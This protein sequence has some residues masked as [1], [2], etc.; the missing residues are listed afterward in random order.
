MKIEHIIEA[1]SKSV[2]KKVFDEWH[3]EGDIL[4]VDDDW[5]SIEIDGERY[6]IMVTQKAVENEETIEAE[7]EPAEIQAE[8]P[9]EVLEPEPK[10]RKKIDHLKILSLHNAG[11]SNKQI[12][13][14]MNLTPNQI[15]QSLS[16]S[17][18]QMEAEE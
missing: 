14:E 4:Y 8:E 12:A 11:W 7:E 1:I 18:K 3:H 17:K 6:Y 10:Q 5:M 9:E 16:R 13:D 2:G 15:S